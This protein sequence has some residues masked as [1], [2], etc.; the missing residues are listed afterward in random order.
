MFIYRKIEKNNNSLIIN[1]KSMLINNNVIEIKSILS[2]IQW[3]IIS[4]ISSVL[5]EQLK[6]YSNKIKFSFIKKYLKLEII[7]SKNLYILIFRK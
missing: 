1:H 6:I 3:I 4:N 5:N 7:K 2:L